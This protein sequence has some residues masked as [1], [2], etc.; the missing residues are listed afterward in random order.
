MLLI[1]GKIG[2]NIAIYILNAGLVSK[3]LKPLFQP[4]RLVKGSVSSD[5]Y[6]LQ[7]AEK[8]TFKTKVSPFLADDCRSPHNQG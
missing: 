4:F 8:V 5:P 3:C 1:H 2:L 6:I 7:K